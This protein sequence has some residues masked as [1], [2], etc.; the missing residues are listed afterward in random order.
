[1]N[2]SPEAKANVKCERER[3]L[4]AEY[5]ERVSAMMWSI[6]AKEELPPLV[7]RMVETS[8]KPLFDNV[9]LT[10]AVGVCKRM[11]GMLQDGFYPDV[12]EGMLD[13][14]LGNLSDFGLEFDRKFRSLMH[15]DERKAFWG[16]SSKAVC[17]LAMAVLKDVIANVDIY[18]PSTDELERS[19]VMRLPQILG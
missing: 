12:V 2:N 1:M 13:C 7:Y 17:I 18:A 8:P 4:S 19:A 3:F 6:R 15:K 11:H 5:R 14:T 10:E 16:T 9:A